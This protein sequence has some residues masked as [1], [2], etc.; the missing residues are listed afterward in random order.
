MGEVEATAP[1]EAG[2]PSSWLASPLSSAKHQLISF[3]VPSKASEINK[4]LT[5]SSIN[6]EGRILKLS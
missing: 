4:N 2:H 1:G 5:E 6:T 3:K